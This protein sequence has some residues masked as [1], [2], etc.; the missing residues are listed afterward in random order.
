MRKA[1][2]RSPS[3]SFPG[4]KSV[5]CPPTDS[6]DVPD[7]AI[8]SGPRGIPTLR[9]LRC[10]A[11]DVTLPDVL[12]R[13]TLGPF[14]RSTPR[15]VSDGILAVTSDVLDTPD[16]QVCKFNIY[17]LPHCTL[18]VCEKYTLRRVFVSVVRG[19]GRQ[20]IW[21]SDSIHFGP[22][23][24]G[25]ELIKIIKSDYLCLREQVK[26]SVA[27]IDIATA[28]RVV[29]SHDPHRVSVGGL[30]P[31]ATYNWFAEFKRGRVNLTE[32][33][34]HGSPST[35]VDNKAIDAVHL[36]IETDRR[37]TYQWRS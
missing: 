7:G 26:L 13:R 35:A 10:P 29:N 20:G 2:V 18:R 11:Q 16:S 6:N 27:D 22:E 8:L 15:S 9:P 17:L 33:F 19:G 3:A 21:V 37:V 24:S 23:D 32:E 36:T 28:T 34:I 14:R 30:R 1:R 5:Q 12:P 25:F 31:K 4:G